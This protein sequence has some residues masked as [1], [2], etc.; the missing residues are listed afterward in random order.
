MKTIVTVIVVIL[1]IAGFVLRV[2]AQEPEGYKVPAMP[3]PAARKAVL[4]KEWAA[5]QANPPQIGVRDCFMFLADALDTR[6]LKDEQV[7]WLLKKVQTRMITDPAAGR[8]YG[9][10]FW[11][12]QERGFDV[13]DGNNVQ[14]CVQYG[15][16]VK[17]LF[18]DRLSKAAVKTLD[19][20]FMLAGN[21]VLNQEVRI[22][23]TNIYLMKIWN[24]LALG[25]VYHRPAMLESGRKLFDTWLNHVA[26][27]GNREY[28]SPTYSGVDMESLLLMHTFLKDNDIKTKTAD[29]LNFLM[30]DLSAHYNKRAGIL[31]G[32][33]SRDYNRV[34]SRD[35][36]EEKYI[37][38]LLGG[39]NNNVHLFNQICLS[40]LQKLGLSASQKELMN[41]KNRFIVQR[42]D[43][44]A[45]TYACDF[46]G[47]K[48]SIAS[49]NQ[50]YSPDDKP[51][52]VYLSSERI[53]AMP[54]IAYVLE[55][56]DDHY[57]TW[58]ATGMGEKMKSR[59]PANYPA[60]G[61]WNKTRHLMP[62]LQSA[63]NKAEFVLLAA[64]EK[65][66]NCTNDY[67]NSTIIL[68]NVF[69]EIWMGNKK[70]NVPDAG[71]GIELD[72]SRTFF[73]RF[74]DVAISFRLIWDDTGEGRASLY[75]DG[76]NYQSSREQFQ[77]KHN[78]TMRLTLRHSNNGKAAIAMWWKVEEGIKT[79][80]DFLKFRKKVL[81]APL[82][83]N[84][85]NG[86]VE[87]AVV[88]ANGKLGVKADLS[89]KKR[90]AYY[91]PSPL[92]ASFL[93]QVDGVEIGRPIMQKYKVK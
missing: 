42:W 93:F 10:I 54:N 4:E 19:E 27:Y 14:F 40:A 72:T 7:E 57:G 78:K 38:P 85:Q 61:G 81:S 48:V 52:V 58:A 50:T 18:N 87:V 75:N 66:H 20:I 67:L 74:E 25:Q 90:L 69:D 41:R 79:A 12:W 26:Q 17:L 89:S 91:N 33:H 31:G 63:Q 80:A 68:P 46:V 86:V 65:D 73:A 5:M 8:I 62:F 56:R 30:T 51:F 39:Q 6:F 47:N 53:P 34:F 15:I 43:S 2:A 71:K 59:M 11:G 83:V 13:G 36:L 9:N 28:D 45:N 76:F 32:A 23:Y 88:T 77:L 92:P 37:N 82:I 22:S 24:L 84:V 3:N 64:G 44:L 29:A 1:S 16:L 60:N 55:G 35:L 21:G 70:I 49:S